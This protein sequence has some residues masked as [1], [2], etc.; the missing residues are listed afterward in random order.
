MRIIRANVGQEKGKLNR[1]F[2]KCIGAGRAAEV[3][4][5]VAFEQLKQIQEDIHFE[6]IRFHGLF[7]EEMG[8]VRRGA[9]G[10]LVYNFQ[11]MDLLFDSLLSIGL[12]PVVELGLMPDILGCEK[13]YVF[14][15]KMN[16]SMPNDIKEWYE[17]VEATVRHFTYRYGEEEVKK[18]YFEIWNEPNH[19][20]FFTESQNID[21]YFELYDSAAR[22]VKSVCKEYRVGGPATAG[23][24]WVRE[25]I[26]H[27]HKENVPL[28]FLS[29]HNYPGRVAF[30]PDGTRQVYL[31]SLDELTDGFCKRGELCH[32]N[33][34]PLLITEWSAS[35]SPRDGVH[36]SYF[37]APL[38]L[39]AIKRCEGKVDMF[40]YWAYTD[41][42][43]EPGVPTTPFHGGFGLVANGCIP[44]PTFW[45]FAFYK[46]LK[47]KAGSC[48]YRDD[49]CVIV[50]T[51]DGEY[52]GILWNM[53]L[54]RKGCSVSL[55]YSFETPAKEHCLLV[56]RVDEN[57]TNPLKVWH[58]LGEPANPSK[59][60]LQLLRESARPLLTTTRLEEGTDTAFVT[61]H[62]KKNAVQYFELLPAVIRSDAGYSYERT[63]RQAIE[64]PEE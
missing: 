26:E 39:R 57:G 42:F 41:I 18:W 22:A 64:D 62:L 31:S 40:S 27:C 54:N 53:T 29:T 37:S 3:M 14:W 13:R 55:N 6:Y 35:A 25:T 20:G 50:K 52:R 36:D 60:E 28:D 7:H 34:Y 5:Y 17:L 23:I 8:V 46:K 47:E 21:K 58:D 51:G 11:Y 9:D 48:V 16:I 10:K 49:N 63:L 30:D 32:E 4:R 59:E 45:T 44:K 2:C 1:Y 43:E 24:A 56:K 12:R 33:G 38:I 19:R 61:L 15:W